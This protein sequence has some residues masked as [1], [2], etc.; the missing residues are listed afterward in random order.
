VDGGNLTKLPPL[1]KVLQ[2][3][4]NFRERKNPFPSGIKIL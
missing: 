4:N 2:V 1:D 3:I